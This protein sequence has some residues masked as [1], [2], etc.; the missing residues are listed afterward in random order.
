MTL[1]ESGEDYL[2]AILKL[3]E[4]RGQVRSID[5]A[6]SMNYSKPSVSRAMGIL[7]R[8]DFIQMDADGAIHLT[9]KGMLIL[10]SD[11]NDL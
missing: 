10:F 9:E 1:H 4:E 7:K 8:Q 6:E 2:E 11:K 5:V 3:R